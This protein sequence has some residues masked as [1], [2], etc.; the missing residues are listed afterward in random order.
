[1]DVHGHRKRVGGRLLGSPHVQVQA[2]L[3]HPAVRFEPVAA[4]G[5]DSDDALTVIAAIRIEIRDLGAAVSLGGGERDSPPGPHPWCSRGRGCGGS[6]DM[7][8][9]R[10]SGPSRGKPTAGLLAPKSLPGI[11]RNNLWASVT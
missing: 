11:R 10:G 4:V 6:H 5:L 7:S 3:A 9:R 8:F 2:V 1:M